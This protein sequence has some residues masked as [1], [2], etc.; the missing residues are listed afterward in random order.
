MKNKSKSRRLIAVWTGLVLTT[1]L[2][3]TSA[4]AADTDPLL[5]LIH[6]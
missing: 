2:L 1:T 5:S 6:I 4:F 3:T